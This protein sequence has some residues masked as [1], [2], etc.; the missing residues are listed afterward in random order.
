MKERKM[1]FVTEVKEMQTGVCNNM[2]AGLELFDWYDSND[3]HVSSLEGQ[4]FLLHSCCFRSIFC[5]LPLSCRST[6]VSRC[7]VA[8]GWC[9]S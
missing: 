2:Y 8:T 3:S 1:S 6:K 9:D 5:F 7:K 4:R